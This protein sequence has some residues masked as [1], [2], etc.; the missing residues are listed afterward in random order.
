MKTFYCRIWAVAWIHVEN[1]NA[2][3]LK[4]EQRLRKRIH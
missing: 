1:E 3:M 2:H 4:F